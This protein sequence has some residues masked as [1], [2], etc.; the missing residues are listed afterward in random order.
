[1]AAT[2]EAVVVAAHVPLSFLVA[3]AGQAVVA[4]A[5]HRTSSRA[6]PT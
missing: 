2:T 6:Q 5:D 3:R 4:A 1:V